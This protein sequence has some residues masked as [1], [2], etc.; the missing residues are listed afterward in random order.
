MSNLAAV[1]YD[2]IIEDFIFVINHP[3]FVMNVSSTGYFFR[4]AQY[5]T[6]NENV[7]ILVANQ[8][9]VQVFDSF[10]WMGFSGITNDSN[11]IITLTERFNNAN[12]RI[13]R[14]NNFSNG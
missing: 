4:I 7:N 6:S 12:N 11:P 1:K 14:L 3:V 5:L 10:M 9:T 13:W 8:N 2:S